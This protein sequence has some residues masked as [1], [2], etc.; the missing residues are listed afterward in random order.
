MCRVNIDLYICLRSKVFHIAMYRDQSFFDYFPAIPY[1]RL[2]MQFL[3]IFQTTE[4]S[5][6]IIAIY[7]AAKGT[8]A[9]FSVKFRV[10]VFA[11]TSRKIE[12][13]SVKTYGNMF[14]TIRCYYVVV[15]VVVVA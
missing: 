11:E 12:N 4:K 7:C 2:L 13:I 9:I 14:I 5:S 10:G 6:T 8:V 3:C 1:E 15:A